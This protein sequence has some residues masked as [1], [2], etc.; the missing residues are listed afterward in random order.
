MNIILFA[1][2]CTVILCHISR[3]LENGKV[4]ALSNRYKSVAYYECDEGYS[5]LGPSTRKCLITGDWSGYTPICVS[6]SSAQG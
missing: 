1:S 6:N 3:E 2:L 4:T 5:L